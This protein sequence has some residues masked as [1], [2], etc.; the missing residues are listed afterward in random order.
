MPDSV[1][2]LAVI[3]KHMTG[4]INP[5]TFL[6]HC[7]PLTHRKLRKLRV[8][9]SG[10]IQLLIRGKQIQLSRN[11]SAVFIILQIKLTLIGCHQ[12]APENTERIKGAAFDQHLQLLFV[13]PVL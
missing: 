8:F 12:T 2:S 4:K 13:Q 3:V 7:Q 5:D 9:E 6:F 1:A 11:R 10:T